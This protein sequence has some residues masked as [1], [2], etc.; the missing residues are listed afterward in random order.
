LPELHPDR[1]ETPACPVR[2]HADRQPFWRAVAVCLLA[3]VF[4][5]FVPGR[6]ALAQAVEF[7]EF[8]IVRGEDGV[9][10][11]FSVRF[12][13]PRAVEDALQKGVPLY[14]VAEADVL[15]ERWYWRDRRIARASRV[16]RLAFQPLTRKYR[17]TFS[18]L[19]QSYDTLAEALT[20]VRRVSGWKLADSAQIEEGARHY[21]EL[22]Y[23]LDTTLLP[24]P[25]QIGIGGQPEWTLVAEKYQRFD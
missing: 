17:V 24:R 20:A 16:W 9:L 21:V 18:G 10:L 15:R 7:S 25:M 23:R 2:W 6:V 8:D 4:A 1:P 12:E 22:S 19:N 11:S 13:L 3:V 14:F 5:L